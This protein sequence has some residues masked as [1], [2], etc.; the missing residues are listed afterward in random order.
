MQ[1]YLQVSISFS[2]YWAN[3]HSEMKQSGIELGSR[4]RKLNSDRRMLPSAGKRQEWMERTEVGSGK[5]M[6]EL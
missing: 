4:K 3:A 6:I 2:R 1:V 5:G